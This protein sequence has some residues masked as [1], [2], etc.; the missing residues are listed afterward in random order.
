M[1]ISKSYDFC[2]SSDFFS[3]KKRRALTNSSNR[4][5]AFKPSWNIKKFIKWRKWFWVVKIVLLNCILLITSKSRHISSSL[6]IKNNF[7]Y[8][9]CQL[10]KLKSINKF[11]FYWLKLC[12][13]YLLLK[14]NPIPSNMYRLVFYIS[15][16]FFGIIRPPNHFF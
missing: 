3:V 7:K 8:F 12:L 15:I 1:Y 5:T 10:F 13:V 9:R 16:I 14:K 11:I 4:C 6:I 2:F